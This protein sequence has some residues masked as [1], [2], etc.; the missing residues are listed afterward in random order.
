MECCSRVQDKT[1]NDF[2]TQVHTRAE[3]NPGGNVVDPS[4]V[5]KSNGAKVFCSLKA[6][7]DQNTQLNA[8]PLIYHHVNER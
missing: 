1:L 4:E 5:K 2:L 8:R 3:S 6:I 7:F